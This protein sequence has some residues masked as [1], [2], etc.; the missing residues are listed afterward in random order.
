MTPSMRAQRIL[1]TL[2]TRKQHLEEAISTVDSLRQAL[3]LATAKAD[4]ASQGGMGL[5]ILGAVL[6]LA[7]HTIARVC[8]NW[9]LEKRFTEWR[10]NRKLPSG[11]S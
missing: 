1:K 9:V 5:V 3:T 11:L 4:L 8:A 10:S 6:V 2:T 7:C